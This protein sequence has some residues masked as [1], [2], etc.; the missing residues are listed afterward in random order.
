MS[1]PGTL[2]YRIFG[3][4]GRPATVPVVLCRLDCDRLAFR[5]GLCGRHYRSLRVYDDVYW[6]DRVP[7]C[8]AA[9]CEQKP[10]GH[11]LCQNHLR[12]FHLL[13]EANLLW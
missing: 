12:R 4:S 6:V 7:E 11:G 5:V 2:E 9:D 8:T 13:R 3:T 10:H 1:E